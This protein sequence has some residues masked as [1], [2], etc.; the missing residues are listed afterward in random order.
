MEHTDVYPRHAS[1]ERWYE[2]MQR[3][4][5]DYGY[6][7]RCMDDI[8]ATTVGA[9]QASA[10]VRNNWHG[11][12]RFYHL[13]PVILD[14]F[15][16]LLSIAVRRGLT[17]EYQQVIPASVGSLILRR[18]AKDDLD[19]RATATPAGS[20]VHG[21]GSVT[22]GRQ[23]IIEI[24]GVRLASFTN[25]Q[26]EESPPITA[27][28]E[29]VP[30][31]ETSTLS[32]ILKPSSK[33]EGAA[34]NLEEYARLSIILAHRSLTEINVALPL[35]SYK[36]W[37]DSSAL[38][39]S[40]SEL[41]LETL[42]SRLDELRELLAAGSTVHISEAIDLVSANMSAILSGQEK[43]S[44]LLE[45]DDTLGK[46][47]RSLE[48]FEDSQFL[49]QAGHEKP[50][51][52]V[53]ELG[54]GIGSMTKTTIES[55]T[56]P[57]GQ[58]L[59]SSFVVS[60]P[61]PGMVEALKAR[62]QAHSNVTVEILD[63]GT[64][65]DSQGFEERGF[66]LII[67]AGILHRTPDLAQALLQ[68]RKLLKPSGRLLLQSLRPSLLWARYVLGLLPEWHIGTE[69]ERAQE[70]YVDAGRWKDLMGSAGLEI[71]NESAPENQQVSNVAQI[72]VARPIRAQS[73]VK[74]ITI[75]SEAKPEDLSSNILVKELSE[76][77]FDLSFSDIASVPP[78]G[79]DIVA[80]LDADEPYVSRLDAD[81][82]YALKKF[83]DNVVDAGI[84][85][86]TQPTNGT[87]ADPAFAQIHGLARCIRSELGL[88][89]ATCEADAK[90]NL[91][92]SRKIADVVELFLNRVND[93]E[94]EPDF[95]YVVDRDSI[96]VNRF[97]PVAEAREDAAA[98]D[99]LGDVR[100]TVDQPGRLDTLHF[101]KERQDTP[102]GNDVQV[103]VHAVGLNFRVSCDSFTRGLM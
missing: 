97:F 13:H 3:E 56:R 33:L 21:E 40:A 25:G 20:G 49:K 72:I 99:S 55:L 73:I 103:E 65:V 14:S 82:F 57:D 12:E 60:D 75:L 48:S 23:A 5:L 54:A 28:S 58:S 70:P 89:F 59:F 7:F 62:F 80:L 69:A 81:R 96:L 15:F 85:W 30:L 77:G 8:R 38:S 43:A 67:A 66:D 52:R 34:S 17:H 36:A 93:D 27:R 92:G 79:Q 1:R 39:S 10:R 83:I 94:I 46:L 90:G 41:D 98:D 102:Q 91:Q 31:I 68:V 101:K 11:D 16:Q 84:L 47:T 19:V 37:L 74:K 35:T 78:P 18:S 88:H 76:R 22:D 53:L 2:T 9:R 87:C 61:S 42:K 32:G 44:E 63:I 64:D 51:L 26:I 86:I 29:W 50:N 100:L 45:L 71:C 6:H 24:S 4:G 95:E